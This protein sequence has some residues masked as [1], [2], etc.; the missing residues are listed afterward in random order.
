[1]SEN[2]HIIP[3]RGSASLID[4]FTP[5]QDEPTKYEYGDAMNLT[6]VDIFGNTEPK[7]KK[8]ENRY[9]P[10][11]PKGDVMIKRMIAFWRVKRSKEN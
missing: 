10:D 7:G 8:D 11:V 2:I 4:D 3:L 9:P 1:M 6:L 5:P